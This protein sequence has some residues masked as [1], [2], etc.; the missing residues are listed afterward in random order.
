MCA[1]TEQK[2]TTARPAQFSACTYVCHR[3]SESCSSRSLGRSHY[4][5]SKA[6]FYLPGRSE[7]SPR[8][9]R[10]RRMDGCREGDCRQCRASKRR[11]REH[12]SFPWMSERI[13]APGIRREGRTGV[14]NRSRSRLSDPRRSMGSR[15]SKTNSKLPF[16]AVKTSHAA[17][18]GECSGSSRIKKAAL[19]S[20]P[21]LEAYSLV[22]ESH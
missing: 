10:S 12:Q 7:R 6:A 20:H 5:L 4:R 13:A 15:E 2:S 16:V 22:L 11:S 3:V 17:F 21:K 18:E 1:E 9:E 19:Y 14:L 8:C